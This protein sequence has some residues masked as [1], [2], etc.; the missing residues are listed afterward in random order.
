[1]RYKKHMIILL[2]AIF[3]F[4]MATASAADLNDTAVAVEDGQ[5]TDE[6]IQTSENQENTI[7]ASNNDEVNLSEDDSG[8]LAIG[9]DKKMGKTV[10]NHTFKAIKDAIDEGESTIYLEPGTYT[11]N[12]SDI[13]ISQMSNIKIIGDSTILD[14]QGK[15]QIFIISQSSNITI[16][17]IIFKN[18]YTGRYGGAIEL[19]NSRDC[20]IS[21]CT[22]INNHAELDGGAISWSEWCDNGRV[23][24]CTFINNHAELDG[25]AISWQT[26]CVNGRVYNCTFI[27]NT[28]GDGGDAIYAD[29]DLNADYNWFGNN[30]DNY[31]DQLPI[32]GDVKCDY[33]L[34]LNA[35]ANPDTITGKDTSN[36]TFKLYQYHSGVI[37]DYDNAPFKNLDLTIT[38]TNGNVK[39]TA[40]LGEPIQFT[41]TRGGTASVTATVEDV[42]QTVEINVGGGDFDLLQD[43]VN[44]ESLS[45]INLER[46]YTYNEF[47][48]IT[49]GVRIT[50]PITINGN[51][52][53]IDAKG[54]SRIFKVT[55]GS[56]NITDV[57]LKNGKADNGGAIYFVNAISNSNI[58]ATYI[59][60]TATR[61]GANDF[62]SVSGSNVSGTYINNTV[63][64]WGGANCFEGSVSGSNVSGTFINNTAE[65]YGGANFFISVLGSNVSGTY[66]NNTA[67]RDGGANYFWSS[68]SGSNVSGTYINNT[69]EWD[70]GAN[71]FQG[72]VSTSN[73]S[74]TYINNTASN[75]VIYFEDYYNEGLDAN[76]TNAIFLNNNCTYEISASTLGIVVK[77]SWFGNNAS[78]FM[79]KPNINDEVQMDGWLFLNGT[80]DHNNIKFF[81]MGYDGTTV[82]EYDNILMPKIN[83]TIATTDGILDKSTVDLDEPVKFSPTKSGI[84]RVTAQIED[85]TQTIEF[86]NGDFDVLQTIVNNATSSVINLTRNYTYNEFDTITEGVRINRPITINGNGFTI[87]AKGKSR[88]F[89]VT[90]GSIN[91]TDV[92]LKNG[93]ADKGGAIIF[94]NDISNSNLNATYINNTAEW[95]GGAN[96][97]WSS[98]LGSNVSGT[99]INN[100]ATYG[101][102]NFFLSSVSTSNISGT[103]INN[104]ATYG[105]ANYFFDSVSGSNIAGTYTNNT[106]TSNGGA[107][108][109]WSGVSGSNIGGTYINNT[110]TSNGGANYFWSGV[111]GSNIGGTYINNTAELAHGG[112]NFFLDSVSGSNISGTYTNNTAEVGGANYFQ[113]SVSGSN[114]SGTYANN[115][116]NDSGGANFFLD[117]VSGS[118][119]TGIYTYNTATNGGGAN[120][121]WYS[122]SGSN[123]AGTYINNTASRSVII[124]F[125]VF[126]QAILTN[127]TIENAIF[128]NNKY[129][130]SMGVIFAEKTGL[131]AKNNWF[132]NNATNYNTQPKT[133]GIQMDSWLFLNAT[134]DPN[135]ISVFDSSDIL[136]KLYSTNGT[137]ISGYDNSKLPVVNLTLTAI[138]GEV[139]NSTVLDKSVE[140]MPTKVG[141]GSVTASVEDAEYTIFLD[142]NKR[143]VNLSVA[144]DPQVIDYG[145]NAAVIL[146]YNATATGTVNITLNGKKHTQTIE[147]VALNKT[148]SLP[149]N[150]L[151]DEYEV[152]VSYSG[153]GVFVNASATSTLTVNQL[154]SDIKVVGYDIYVNDT[155]GLI[156][157]VTLPENATGN[158]TI[159]NTITLNVTK[160]GRKENN[161]LII[162]IMNNAYPVGEYNWT[163]TYS[164]D[165]IYENSEANATANILIIP[166]EIIANATSSLF[167]DDT[168]Q[169][170]YNVTPENAVGNVKFTSNDTSV[171]EVDQDGNIRAI[172]EGTALITVTFEGCE[173]YTAS[174]TNVTVTV[175]K[176]ATEII[177]TN[178]TVELKAYENISDL[179]TLAPAGAGNLTYA[180]SD[181]D[182]VL[183]SEDGIIYAR[184]KGTANVTVS[185]AGDNKYK[186]AE[187]KTITVTVTL[188]DASVSVENDTIDLYVD[189]TCIINATANPRFLTVYYA[190]SNE[191]VATVTEYGNVKAVGEGTAI[192]TLTVGNGET[193]AINSTNVTV[194]VSKVPTEITVNTASLDLFV[195]DETIINATLTP[196]GAGNVTFIS[197]DYDVV[198]FDDEGNV[199]AQGK[200]QAIITVSFAG[201]NKYAAAENKTITVTVSLNDASV[202]VDND[203]LDL[204]VGETYKINATK[205][206]DTILLDIAYSSSNSS[207]VG[208]DE[209]GIVTAVGEGTA[210]I[211]VEVGDDVIYAKNSTNITVTVSK[212]LTEIIV[213]N[214]TIDMEV[215]DEVTPVVSLMPSDAGELDF[216]SSDVSVVTVDGIG[217]ITAVGEGIA[218]V[219]IRF[220]GNDKYAAAES[221]NI[222]VTVSLKDASVSVNNSTLDLKVDDTFTIVP[223]TAP[224]GLNVTYVPDDSGVYS[225]D[226]KGVVTALKEGTATIIVKVGGDGIYA[227][228]TTSITVTVNKQDANASVSIPENVTV[229]EDSNIE[230]T[231]PSDAT[232][233]I[234]LKVDGEIV[235]TVPVADGSANLTLPSLSAGN[236]TV[237]IAYSGDEKYNPVS[238][239]KDITVSKQDTTPE[240]DVEGS[241][242][243]VKLPG[244]AAGNVTVKVDDTV[245]S[246]VPV[247]DG[248]A[249]VKLPKLSAGNHTVEIAYSGNDKYK[250]SSKT[251]TIS[252]DKDSTKLAADNVAATYKV[253]KYL[254]ITLTDSNGSPIANATVSVELKSAKNYTSD[255][256]GQIKVKVSNLVPK[257]YTAKITFKGDDNY[258]GS[259]ITAKVTVKKATSKI[260]VK[261]KTFKTTTKTKKYTVTLKA[262]GKALKNKWV[263]L[264]VNGKTYKAKTN[265]KGKA[266]FKITQLNKAGKYKATVTFKGNDYYKK[267]TKKVII[268]VKSVWKTVQKGSKNSAIVK[269]I[270]RALKNHGYYLEYNGRYLKVD[271]I[272]WDYTEMAV[273][274]FQN[275]KTLKVTGKV[276]EKTAKKL[277]II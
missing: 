49:G 70:G 268:K 247:T 192:I 67:E 182:I 98:V 251:A 163:F 112:A 270:Q 116:A 27:N 233:N 244:D 75:A 59:N 265:S 141:Q 249:S 105:G 140:Y 32:T 259:N 227:E 99:Y 220:I 177:L 276:D 199:I 159:S 257:T 108:Y 111:S 157:T 6:I 240:I 74:G 258:I 19:Y 207:V 232:G 245:V 61:G 205:N 43:L 88:I 38:A 107:N 51:G 134:A 81:L 96:F 250:S 82:S 261:A 21:N 95:Y 216:T 137:H 25:G 208:V 119:I 277:G 91:I 131:V 167:V 206:P 160:E 73:I 166:T 117:S 171:V 120:Y 256:N 5:L 187:N 40:K 214:A 9:N 228:N 22:F 183:V 37:S 62:D 77:D 90:A 147:S 173:N 170:T 155:T 57:T 129:N 13:Y 165:D 48:T 104:N 180:S 217:T 127:V 241:N 17:N 4:A 221:K 36:I 103:Y 193:Y 203:T 186:A 274:E 52:F 69:A 138:N 275:D 63:K 87:N 230:I 175:S 132:G 68:V 224:A 65:L 191:S 56:I 79:N 148:I 254:T 1:M 46:S 24:N 242:V 229:G 204:K 10:T 45:V 215:T 34:F 136:F 20:S 202:T 66:I 100:N 139:S 11:G 237:E 222:T 267:A 212:I 146:E 18:G 16:Q 188:N 143:D 271:G 209:N 29:D 219:T 76:I 135:P 54:K 248:T 164:G 236:H 53:T 42:R 168:D 189:D 44:N 162:E 97:F 218:N 78:N 266:T 89:Y 125:E 109:F 239:T 211:T 213:Q 26:L 64:D 94:E 50:R 124:Y 118:N 39:G 223:T 86:T 253:K 128:L 195:G 47:D 2:A 101:G 234:T 12:W 149:D 210:T 15:I 197:S 156:F 23:S 201:D 30:A 144:V 185:F 178:A 151:P 179:A 255:E 7:Q 264:K 152:I 273:K 126:D 145:E 263:Y 196:A 154:K 226:D 115:T 225:I 121:F 262:N 130:E 114:I 93:K 83:L 31:N 174:S 231:L 190:S 133:T 198:D 153:D 161:S 243:D 35:T 235:D 123:I 110:A 176:I 92:T 41:P 184:V 102:A 142:N 55:A 58:N 28:A 8:K 200:G 272:F 122:V 260:T 252:V 194:T 172:A 33:R 150:I 3:L 106:A 71:Y 158:I 169:V 246:T 85:A 181:E 60:N 113:D 80:N 14:A 238:E 84:N 269:K 72:S